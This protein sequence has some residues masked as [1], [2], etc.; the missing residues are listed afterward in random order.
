MK[1]FLSTITILFL[2]MEIK[3]FI[4]KIGVHEK[5]E[6]IE[7]IN[8]ALNF[9]GNKKLTMLAISMFDVIMNIFYSY[10]I[11]IY[12]KNNLVLPLTFMFVLVIVFRCINLYIDIIV[13]ENKNPK[14]TLPR[15]VL[16]FYN[17]AFLIYIFYNLMAK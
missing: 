8:D 5:I 12:L 10:F 14:F 15:M 13:H 9:T 6:K 7:G 3:G 11:V 1:I 2:F 17:M 16:S 4:A